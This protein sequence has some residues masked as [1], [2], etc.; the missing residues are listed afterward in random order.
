MTSHLL[1]I[2]STAGRALPFLFTAYSCGAAEPVSSL[3]VFSI[4]PAQ[5]SSKEILSEASEIA[6]SVSAC[7]D[8]SSDLFPSGFSLNSCMPVFRSVSALAEN[9]DA[10]FL[11][12]ALRGNSLSV[13][14]QTDREAVEWCF[15]D[16][17]QTDD[18]SIRSFHT[19]LDKLR[20]FLQAAS[21]PS[22]TIIAD[23]CDP[24]SAGIVL[25]LLPYLRNFLKETSVCLHYLALSETCCPLPDGYHSALHSFISEISQR[26]LL[27]ESLTDEPAGADSLWLISL[28][29]SMADSSDS[30]ALPA[31][32][33]SRVLVQ[34]ACAED[35][36]LGFHSVEADGVLSLS[37][38]KD[39]ALPFAAFLDSSVWLL[40]DLLPSL[41]NWL[42]HPARLRSLTVNP[43]IS[44]FRHLFSAPGGDLLSYIDKTESALRDLLSV[45]LRFLR[46]VPS[47]FRFS[48]E[49]D[50]LWQNAVNACG[51]FITVASELDTSTAEA[52]ESGLDSVRPVHRASMADTD[53]EQL[54]HKLEEIA[55]QLENE[56]KERDE[57]LSLIGGYRAFQVKLDCLK[58]CR[59]AL[60]DAVQTLSSS[61][62]EADHLLLLRRERRVR[63]LQNAVL[64]CEKELDPQSVF[65]TVSL[66]P[67]QKKASDDPY[68]F[69]VLSV[70]FCHF[71]VNLLEKK[72]DEVVSR[73]PVLFQGD[74]WQDDLKVRAKSLLSSFKNDFSEDISPINPFSLF[75]LRVTNLSRNF[76]SGVRFLPLSSLPSVLLLPDLISDQPINS[77]HDL[78]SRLPDA[79]SRESD[80][81]SLRGMLAM[82]LLRQYRRRSSSEAALSCISCASDASPVLRC[83]LSAH[84]AEKVYILFLAREDES[85][86][87]L[88]ILPGHSLI[89]ARLSSAVS[90]LIPSFAV[91]FDADT[92]SFHDP[93]VSLGEGD[94]KLLQNLLRSFLD[95]V[96]DKPDSSLRSFLSSFLGD[97]VLNGDSSRSVDPY[98]RIRLQASCAL[99]K[100]PA[101]NGSLEKLSCFYEHFLGEDVIGSCITGTSDFPASPCTDIP[102]ETLYLY[103]GVP[104]A[105]E[106]AAYLLESPCAADEDYT[107]KRLKSECDTL[108]LVSDDYRDALASGLRDLLDRNPDVLPEI[109]D[110]ILSIL[111]DAE[112]PVERKE[113]EFIWPWDT[114]SPSILTV[115]KESLGEKISIQA[116]DPFSEM[117][118][119]FPARSGDVIGDSLFSSVCTVSSPDNQS[120]DP[121]N[122]SQ[123]RSDAV[124]P[125]LSPEFGRSLCTF[126][127]GRTLLK[128]GLLS[129]EPLQNDSFRVTLTL[130]GVF[131]VHL[132]RIYKPEEVVHL[133]SHEIPT[134]ALWPS[135]PFRPDQWHAYYVYAHLQNHWSV[136]ACTASLD[137]MVLDSVNDER[138]TTVFETFPLCFSFFRDGKTAGALPNVLPEP[139]IKPSDP[140]T[141]CVDFGSSCTSVVF[142]SPQKRYPM[143]GPTMVRTILNNP[144]FSKDLLRLEFLPAV[145]VSALLPMVSR[146]FRNIPGAS[147]VPLSDGIILMSSSLQD[148]LSTPSDAIYS[149]LKWEEKGRSGTLC[150]HQALLMTALQARFEGASS[151]FWRFA[152][153]DEMASEGR[154]NLFNLFNS[155][156][157]DVLVESGYSCEKDRSPV[158][159]ASDSST[160]GSYF[161][162]CAPNDT[163][164][165][166][167]TLDI[168]ACT[169]DI[170][171]FLRGREQAIRTCQIPLG[172]Q[173]IFLPSCL[174]S[175]EMISNDFCI[176]QDPVFLQDLALLT[177]ALTAA[178]T[179]PVSLR[180][181]RVALDYFIA[182][183]HQLLISASLQMA[184]AGRPTRSGALLLLHLS[185]LMMLAGLFLLQ[186]SS[187]PS[188]NEFLP[189]QM[190]LFLS[191]RG[192]LLME[193]LPSSL[194]SSLWT[195]LTMFRN[196]R[197]SSVSLIFSAEK[198]MEI[199]V[200]LSLLQEL[201]STLPP[202]S[203]IPS[204]LSV[205]PAE[206]LP[207]FMLRFH[208]E[209]PVSSDLLFPGFFTE[210]PYHPFT[211]RG[212]S[213]V[214]SSID[215]SFPPSDVPR[216]FDSLAA[217]IGNLLDLL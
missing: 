203:A 132:I 201:Y 187:D 110:E 89:P 122:A 146:I 3:N 86:P 111:D 26:R 6:A 71:I 87:I 99:F 35:P 135:V 155:V 2:G 15:S 193:S 13:S 97:L 194:Q 129:F 156:C 121:E 4:L 130:D 154:E 65:A 5:S 118:A 145:P 133:Y 25:S 134:V 126:P 78:L 36:P 60:D 41:R 27:R 142:S 59:S 56:E 195:F 189:E 186:I 21:S 152:L 18:P 159:F 109:R 44:L 176:C 179:D 43:R 72:Q 94:R 57:A 101:Y 96:P 178:R 52:K 11:I 49:Y 103:R 84:Q 210:D 80:V 106:N 174:R 83:W 206:L 137:Y 149:S 173:Y 141:V 170:S 115:M 216:P 37:S 200:G 66:L 47:A 213:V 74:S 197:V 139:F 151:L 55:S 82:L 29:S 185:Y 214:F 196:R 19:W 119:L 117:L 81:P 148:L 136:S 163:R 75:L 45:I 202:P 7:H 12:T 188:R 8:F 128:P 166:F 33:T 120:T 172:I 88:L 100:L 157:Q 182:D 131:P 171:L 209:F 184:S 162:F 138:F 181:A 127:E 68:A 212:D 147:P 30:F 10:H 205:R 192:S 90:S 91:W 14:C 70:D 102:G 9:P 46:G 180:R 48:A 204:S 158:Q 198:K 31:L 140:V 34:C 69:S 144:A 38:L 124:L 22:L 215:Q 169:A 1:C 32:A 17:L 161:R 112:K 98:F 76:L 167:M 58:R 190:S 95:V 23:P 199:P 160:L 191:G 62:P 207:E 116:L 16:L 53:E 217:W 51:R 67:A 114:K 77:I 40:S 93:C 113:P 20:S 73:L 104:F 108:S 150:L 123:I 183:Y 85:V 92:L 143:Q 168:G 153:P 64:R 39:Q 208:R 61:S 164:G 28:P 54:I 175:P 165:G 107:L 105:R 63:L 125:P 79:A 42:S 177:R 50:Q 211:D 24:F